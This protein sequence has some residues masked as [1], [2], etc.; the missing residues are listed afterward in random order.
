MRP[1]EF[2]QWSSWSSCSAC[3]NERQ[4][5]ERSVNDEASQGSPIC[6]DVSTLRQLEESRPCIH[7]C[8]FEGTDAIAAINFVYL[9][10]TSRNRLSI[11]IPA[12]YPLMSLNIHPPSGNVIS[13]DLIIRNHKRSLLEEKNCSYPD[14]MNLILNDTVSMLKKIGSDKVSLA[15][16]TLKPINSTCTMQLRIEDQPTFPWLQ[17][18]VGA[19]AVLVFIVIL[20]LFIN[21]YTQIQSLKVIDER[22]T[23]PFLS[24]KK[25]LFGISWKLKKEEE[26][27]NTMKLAYFKKFNRTDSEK[28]YQLLRDHLEGKAIQF[29]SVWGVYNKTLISRFYKEYGIWSERI[30]NKTIF[31]K[32]D[33]RNSKDVLREW[34]YS[35]FEERVKEFDWN[36][37]E[38]IPI[39]PVIHG[40]SLGKAFKI[41]NTGFAILSTLD[42][43]YY[44]QGIYV[45]SYTKYALQYCNGAVPALIVAYLQPGNPY[46]VIESPLNP[47]NFVGKPV[48]PGHQCNYVRVSKGRGYPVTAPTEK[49]YDEFVIGQEAFLIPV[50]IVQISSV[51]LINLQKELMRLDKSAQTGYDYE[52]L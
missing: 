45:T 43:G 34:V 12:S 21:V 36:S 23:W 46:P 35:Q 42:K 10:W 2:E 7:S 32:E 5:R 25:D 28:V 30:K 40:T 44:G 29:E 9:E 47:D 19:V 48:P 11:L 1:C 4:V 18:L 17:V 6:N 26:S 27:G 16:I 20:G 3:K 31:Q 52:V 15:P 33:W 41:C 38:K 14:I 49:S 8:T 24:A 22:L 50:F 37:G 51:E 13:L 39:V